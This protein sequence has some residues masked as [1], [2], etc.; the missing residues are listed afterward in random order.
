VGRSRWEQGPAN[1][2][3]KT[4]NTIR[5]VLIATA[6]SASIAGALTGAA[7]SGET[8]QIDTAQTC[9]TAHW[10]MIPAECLEGAPVREV[11]YA[12]ATLA[13]LDHNIQERFN[14]AFQ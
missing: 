6:F 2:E 12:T 14:V 1:K 3:G 8:R 10:P 13:S 4:M 7:L 9:A 11:R 5:K